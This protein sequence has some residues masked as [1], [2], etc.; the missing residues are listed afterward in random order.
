[1]LDDERGWADRLI[2]E[3]EDIAVAE[4][5]R[6]VHL[7][8]ADVLSAGRGQV[9]VGSQLTP[10][11][12]LIAELLSEAVVSVIRARVLATDSGPLVELAPSLMEH[13]VE[14][15]LGAGAEIADR[16][17]DPSLPPRTPS[18]AKILPV[19]AHPRVLQALRV[20]AETPDQSTRKVELELR[21]TN[22]RGGDLSQVLNPLLRR[23]LIENRR[24]GAPGNERNAWRLTAYGHRA[25][26]LLGDSRDPRSRR[27]GNDAVAKAGEAVRIGRRA[28]RRAA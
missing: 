23:G 3:D 4:A 17:S 7:A 2:I 26:D 8:L 9:I 15:Y 1:L 18:E 21:A 19:R 22:Q 10:P 27:G 13:V 14:P 6:S 20:I 5:A 12:T 11:T 24:A 16:I 28:R 25:L